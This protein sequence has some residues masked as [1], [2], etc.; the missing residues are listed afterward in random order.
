MSQLG[1]N[2]RTDTV[3]NY[4]SAEGTT[5]L[6]NFCMQKFTD[7][8]TLLA[9]ESFSDRRYSKY[10]QISRSWTAHWDNLNTLFNYREDI[11]RAMY[12]T[13]AIESLNSVIRKVS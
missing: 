12:T 3:E 1:E 5:P 7:D 4:R 11:R 13:N 10:L 6:Q 2:G 8:E 9:L